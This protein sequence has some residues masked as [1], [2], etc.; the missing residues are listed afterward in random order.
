[1]DRVEQ[2]RFQAMLNEF[3]R[4]RLITPL[5]RDIAEAM[6]WNCRKREDGWFM[7]G[8]KQLAGMARGCCRDTVNEAIKALEKLGCLLK[9]RTRVW[10]A[11]LGSW[12][13]G[14]NIYRLV[15][16]SESEIP[17]PDSSKNPS[18]FLLQKEVAHEREAEEPCATPP[19]GD[20]RTVEDTGPG[21]GTE[22]PSDR[23]T[24]P[25][26]TEGSGVVADEHDS[27]RQIYRAPHDGMRA[28]A[29]RRGQRTVQQDLAELAAWRRE[30]NL[31]RGHILA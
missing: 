20:A 3:R 23:G 31:I 26:R 18:S 22:I 15:L 4:L 17:T 19:S 6:N 13:Q 29:A 21:E 11:R 7:A 8:M 28:D 12:V 16:L 1:M 24:Q 9:E 5:T 30:I 14:K 10:C 27:A 2:H 25:G